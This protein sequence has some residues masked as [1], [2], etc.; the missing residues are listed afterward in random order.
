MKIVT[1]PMWLILSFLLGALRYVV[2]KFVLL[3]EFCD[4]V[5]LFL[6]ARGFWIESSLTVGAFFSFLPYLISRARG[7][8]EGLGVPFLLWMGMRFSLVFLLL[9]F[10]V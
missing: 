9:I 7:V 1:F 6:H 8:I 3:K 5:N 10:L 2:P 4:L